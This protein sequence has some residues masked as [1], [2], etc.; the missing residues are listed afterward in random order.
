MSYLHL[1]I[2][3]RHLFSIPHMQKEIEGGRLISDIIMFTWAKKEKQLCFLE[4]CSEEFYFIFGG[5]GFFYYS[6]RKTQKL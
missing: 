5:G 2:K 3:K 4:K 1:I 6:N